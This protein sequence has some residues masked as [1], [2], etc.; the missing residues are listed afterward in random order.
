[1]GVQTYVPPHPR[2]L[3]PGEREKGAIFNLIEKTYYSENL[4]PAFVP[5]GGTSRRQVT[6]LC[7]IPRKAGPFLKGERRDL[8]IDVHA[9][10]HWLVRLFMTSFKESQSFDLQ[11]CPS[12]KMTEERVEVKYLLDIVITLGYWIIAIKK[13]SPLLWYWIKARLLS[14]TNSR[15]S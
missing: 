11:A 6:P 7:Q 4:P 15:I 8:V 9:I 10:V 3:P 5:Q 13:E 12:T 1:M 2:P 14:T